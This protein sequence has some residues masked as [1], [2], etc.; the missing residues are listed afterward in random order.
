MNFKSTNIWFVIFLSL[1]VFLFYS[2]NSYRYFD[3]FIDAQDTYLLINGNKENF[4]DKRLL[5]N[6]T[7]YRCS[8]KK[9]FFCNKDNGRK[10][11]DF[12]YEYISRE[13][14]HGLDLYYIE[15]D[16]VY[17][18]EETK[19]RSYDLKLKETRKLSEFEKQIYQ[20]LIEHSKK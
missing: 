20:N 9:G 7:V 14:K 15:L 6:K 3:T 5:Y 8:L 2:C 19:R 1:F 10:D 11:P 13:S 12:I 17:V 18:F 16:S 4:G